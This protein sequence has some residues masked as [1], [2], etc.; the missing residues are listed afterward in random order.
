MLSSQHLTGSRTNQAAQDL[1]IMLAAQRHLTLIGLHVIVPDL[2]DM[3]GIG[4]AGF[5]GTGYVNPAEYELEAQ[6][7]TS[8]RQ[9]AQEL[10]K[11]FMARCEQA[12][13]GCVPLSETGGV[14]ED[15]LRW[16]HDAHA[17]WLSREGL[18]AGSTTWFSS[19][20]QVVRHSS[21]PVWI[22]HEGAQVTQ[23]VTVAYDG[24]PQALGALDVAASLSRE[25][26]LPLELLVVSEGRSTGV[27]EGT[28]HDAQA[29]LEAFGHSANAASLAEGHPAELLSAATGPD[30][31][32][33][34][35]THSHGTFLGFRRGHTVDDVLRDAQGSVLLCPKEV[36]ER[37]D[38]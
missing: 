25:W 11:D 13:V 18:H 31:L 29:I 1:A 4:P 27:N 28:M 21:V 7:L 2:V 35:G 38:D 26:S 24:H 12:R 15:I 5:T 34:M 9:A 3:T 30:R 19:F 10:L 33:V 17:I 23:R 8:K 37:E 22:A 14:T 32:L 36:Q 6:A 16:A 20:E